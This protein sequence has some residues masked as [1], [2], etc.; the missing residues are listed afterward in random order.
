MESLGPDN[1]ILIVDD[2][3][4]VLH[5]LEIGLSRLESELHLTCSGEAGLKAARELNPVLVVLDILMPDIDGYE[6]CRQFRQFSTEPVIL[7]TAL[8]DSG[9]LTNALAAG[10]DEFV[11]KPFSIAD[12]LGRCRAA[13]ARRLTPALP[14]GTPATLAG[15]RFTIDAERRLLFEQPRRRSH[16]PDVVP[17]SNTGYRLISYL[18]AN[19][20]RRLTYAEVLE[21][22]WGPAWTGERELLRAHLSVLRK[23]LELDA[24]RP[25]I[26]LDDGDDL[27]QF[28]G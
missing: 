12:L 8:R 9:D 26:I 1:H 16:A 5:L 28:G 4:S 11:A 13:L 24:S 22:I 20:G 19:K 10:A 21:N 6:V 3:P 7:L 15:G 23:A 17:L 25:S 27:L 2:E 18:A 14:A